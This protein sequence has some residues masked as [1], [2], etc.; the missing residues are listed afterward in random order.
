[1]VLLGPC[2]LPLSQFV[3]WVCVF[4]RGLMNKFDDDGLWTTLGLHYL[5]LFKHQNSVS[6]LTHSHSSPSF[7]SNQEARAPVAVLLGTSSLA[8][9]RR[10]LN[11]RCR[12]FG[13][14]ILAISIG[15]MLIRTIFIFFSFGIFF[16]CRM[17]IHI[18][19]SIHYSTINKI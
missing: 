18:N 6:K 9:Q 1:M 4:V 16:C 19:F 13:E 10:R 7:P 11:S 2:L 8:T 14:Y 15:H 17:N 5:L 12:I 3:C